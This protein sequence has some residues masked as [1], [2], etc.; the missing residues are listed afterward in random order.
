MDIKAIKCPMC[1]ENIANQG[2]LE[3][4]LKEEKVQ[5]LEKAS[6][7]FKVWYA[8]MGDKESGKERAYNSAIT[9][10]SCKCSICGG[11]LVVF[12][13]PTGFN[14]V[15]SKLG[16]MIPNRKETCESPCKA[17][18]WS[19]ESCFLNIKKKEKIEPEYADFTETEKPF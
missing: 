15:E 12:S 2:K 6:N 7:H 9:Q 13:T 14:Q 4:M 19:C 8:K 11:Q 16:V 10:S 1:Q 3:D 17:K 18:G 5:G